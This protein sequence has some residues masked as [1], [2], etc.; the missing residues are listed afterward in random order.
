MLAIV[1]VLP[2]PVTP[3]SVWNARPSSTPSTSVSIAVGLVAGGQVRL[4]KLE[5]RAFERD[6]FGFV[7]RIVGFS[8]MLFGHGDGTGPW[9]K[10]HSN[11]LRETRIGSVFAGLP[12]P[13]RCGLRLA[14]PERTLWPFARTVRG[15]FAHGF[16][17]AAALSL[18]AVRTP[19]NGLRKAFFTL[20]RSN[21]MTPEC[22]FFKQIIPSCE[23]CRPKNAR[24]FVTMR[25]CARSPLSFA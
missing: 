24:G 19:C 13:L 25:S 16:A 5:R 17:A 22:L 4:V 8:Q 2:E 11:G 18:L 6:E 1:K 20:I 15:F 14:G 12:G 23:P 3:S 10:D 7:E 9:A 21:H